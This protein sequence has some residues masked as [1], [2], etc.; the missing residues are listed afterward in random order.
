MQEITYDMFHSLHAIACTIFDIYPTVYMCLR[1]L[2]YISGS[3]VILSVN[4][5]LHKTDS[6]TDVSFFS[7]PPYI[8]VLER[9]LVYIKLPVDFQK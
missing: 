5:T 4:M 7:L 2:S 8:A 9:I 3:P 1:I 6:M